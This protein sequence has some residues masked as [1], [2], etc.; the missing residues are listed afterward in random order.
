MIVN[1]DKKNQMMNST[2]QRYRIRSVCFI[3]A[4]LLS[5][6]FT[7]LNAQIVLMGKNDP[8]ANVNDGDFKAVWDY[9][10]NASQ[11][12]FWT[13]KPVKGDKAMGLHYGT[14][15]SS[16]DE[17]FADSKILNTNP[18][19]QVPR[20]GDILQWSFGADLEYKSDGKISL[21]FVFGDTERILLQK[22]S[23]LG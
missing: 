6:M 17:G 3:F 20:A 5:F 12:P 10:R 14:L 13:T 8:H 23:L 15:F 9:W 1:L 21:S 16:N 4:L 11:S 18:Q 2:H 7:Q 22:A 19:Y